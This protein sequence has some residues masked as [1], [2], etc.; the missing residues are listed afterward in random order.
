M[1][2]AKGCSEEF[3]N[4]KIDENRWENKSYELMINGRGERVSALRGCLSEIVDT[5]FDFRSEGERVLCKGI[6]VR[7]ISEG[8]CTR[9][10]SGQLTL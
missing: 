6:S 9:V 10:K 5:V 3:L 2:F 8:R 1:L 7:V 4:N